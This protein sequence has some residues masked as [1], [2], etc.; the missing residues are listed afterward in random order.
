M[1]L[2]SAA[3]LSVTFYGVDSTNLESTPLLRALSSLLQ[4]A[5][6]HK[7]NSLLYIANQE[8]LNKYDDDLWTSVPWLPHGTCAQDFSAKQPILITSSLCNKN[9]ANTLFTV[10]DLQLS[11]IINKLEG[12]EKVCALFSINNVGS[13]E[14]FEQNWKELKD[15][16]IILNYYKQ[17]SEGKFTHVEK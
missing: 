13:L 6:E 3:K 11:T 1:N 8:T 2:S 14:M 16:K 4:K 17:G 12:I 15:K 7:R 10:E 5:I 9:S